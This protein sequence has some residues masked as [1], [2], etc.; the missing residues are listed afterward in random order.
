MEWFTRFMSAVQKILVLE[1]R[2]DHLDEGYGKIADQ[3]A[4]LRD[5]VS[6]IEGMFEMMMVQQGMAR[7]A[8]TPT[9][10]TPEQPKLPGQ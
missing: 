7:Q 1:K 6:R 10:I 4:D 5:R 2:I 3:M 9:D 8:P